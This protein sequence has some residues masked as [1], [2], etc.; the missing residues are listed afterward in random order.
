MLDCTSPVQ[1]EWNMFVS[2]NSGS[3]YHLFE[4]RAVFE[5]AYQLRTLYLTI[6]EKGVLVGILPIAIMPNFPGFSVKAVSLPYCN[7]GG[8]L[9][10]NGLDPQPILASVI[11][12]LTCLGIDKV[13]L[14]DIAP[15]MFDTAEVTMILGLPENSEMLWKQI[16]DKARNQVRKA[17]KKG[18]SLRWGGGSGR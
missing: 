9:V 8:L 18:L 14:R 3:Y 7:Y 13:E 11:N 5:K 2:R 10:A 6:R 12:N 1:N 16:G 17:Q 4:W 15:G